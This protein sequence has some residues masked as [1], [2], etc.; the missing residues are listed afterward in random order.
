MKRERWN[1]IAR[2][3]D[4]DGL[5]ARVAVVNR[6]PMPRCQALR[7]VERLSG[8]RTKFELARQDQPSTFEVEIDGGD[9]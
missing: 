3:I 5:V 4:P 9:R 8:H 6:A 1:V 2:M 7:V